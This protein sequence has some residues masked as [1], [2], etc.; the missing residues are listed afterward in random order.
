LTHERAV[1][2][3][4]TDEG[5]RGYEQVF[6]PVMDVAIFVKPERWQTW[7]VTATLGTMTE[8]GYSEED[9]ARWYVSG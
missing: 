1:A 7:D 3:Y 5:E 4:L 9:A 2:P 6:L 8:H